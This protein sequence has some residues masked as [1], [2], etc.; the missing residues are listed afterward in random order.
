MVLKLSPTKSCA[1]FFGSPD[2][3]H[4]KTEIIHVTSAKPVDGKNV[5]SWHHYDAILAASF[6]CCNSLPI[7]DSIESDTQLLYGG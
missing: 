5:F 3:S 1:I 7:S 6:I 2:I 4:T